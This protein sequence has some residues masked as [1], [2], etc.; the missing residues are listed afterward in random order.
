[1][2]AVLNFTNTSTDQNVSLTIIDDQLLESD[3]EEFVVTLKR[4]DQ[5]DD[6]VIL[7]P[8]LATVTILDNDSEIID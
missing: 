5:T 1:M 6:R 8:D 2:S 7:E 4:A 3:E